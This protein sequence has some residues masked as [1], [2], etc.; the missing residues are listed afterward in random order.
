MNKILEKLHW[1]FASFW[2]F[3]KSFYYI[4]SYLFSFVVPL[5]VILWHSLSFVFTRCNTRL[6]FYKR[7]FFMIKIT[8]NCLREKGN[9]RKNIDKINFASFSILKG[10]KKTKKIRS[11]LP[12]VNFSLRWWF[13]WQQRLFFSSHSGFC[14]VLLLTKHEL[15]LFF[16]RD[17]PFW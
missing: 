11:Y 7:S 10:L 9:D 15:N 8:W 17:W 12:A 16:R 3:W 14:S 4:F 13:S 5:A 6:S 1:P 2:N